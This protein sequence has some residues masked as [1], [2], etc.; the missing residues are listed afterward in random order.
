M[1]TDDQTKED[2]RTLTGRGDYL[3]NRNELRVMPAPT[4]S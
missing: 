3:L 2:I 4:E 1:H